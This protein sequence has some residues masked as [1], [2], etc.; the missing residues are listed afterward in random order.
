MPCN[1]GDY[2]NSLGSSTSLDILPTNPQTVGSRVLIVSDA[3]ETIP[4][5]FDFETLP[6]WSGPESTIAAPHNSLVQDTYTLYKCT[7]PLGA[8][9]AKDFRIFFSHLS[10]LSSDTHIIV[11][12][13][14]DA[15]T[16]ASVS[17]MRGD[18]N[19]NIVEGGRC[20]AKAQ[21]YE[22]L[23]AITP[24]NSSLGP[25]AV[26]IWSGTL[27]ALG[28]LAGVIE[29]SITAAAACNLQLRICV[30]PTLTASYGSWGDAVAWPFNEKVP[31]HPNTGPEFVKHVRGWWPY[32]SLSL[33]CAALNI[34]PISAGPPP[35]SETSVCSDPNGPEWST[36]GF[37]KRAADEF[38][39]SPGNKGCYGASLNYVFFVS[40]YPGDGNSYPFD[41][42]MIARGTDKAWYGAARIVTPSVFTAKGVKPIN[43]F[44]IETTCKLTVNAAGGSAPLSLASGGSTFVTVSLA[45][46]SGSTLPVN[47][48]LAGLIGFTETQGGG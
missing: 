45:N 23:G 8:S 21:L 32:S 1:Q 37:G 11:N 10:R 18:T 48:R 25:I 5:L 44:G 9:V 27:A 6:L 26:P 12:C 24:T 17:S 4:Q 3:P 35:F 31:V 29:F 15:S 36:S 41:V 2:L 30:A 20:L 38:G 7:I 33:E 34:Q 43:S 14:L 13:S 40:N 28:F 16:T 42:S 46:G 19:S 39:T 22:T 47:L